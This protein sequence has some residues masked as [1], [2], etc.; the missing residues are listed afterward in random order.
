MYLKLNG[1]AFCGKSLTKTYVVEI[2]RLTLLCVAGKK[3]A[4]GKNEGNLHYVIENKWRNNVRNRAFHYVDE[5]KKYRGRFPL[6]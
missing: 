1:L 3:D 5:N 4:G 2:T 6:Y